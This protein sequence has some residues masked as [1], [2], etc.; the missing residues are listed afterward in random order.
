M[1]DG[2]RALFSKPSHPPAPSPPS[3]SAEMRPVP[4]AGPSSTPAKRPRDPSPS[5]S[6]T[7]R[8][9]TSSDDDSDGGLVAPAL[10]GSQHLAL[11]A[12]SPAPAPQPRRAAAVKREEEPDAAAP[13]AG[14]S[15]AAPKA[16][17]AR[18]GSALKRESTAEESDDEEAEAEEEE[19]QPPSPAPKRRRRSS[20]AAKS[21]K[22]KGKGK[23][24]KEEAAV[25]EEESEEDD[26]EVVSKAM[27]A[28][29]LNDAES[30]S[31]KRLR[32]GSAP[33][34]HIGD[35]VELHPGGWHACVEDIRTL[36]S[37]VRAAVDPGTTPVDESAK[38]ALQLSW[39][40][41][42]E[43]LLA[44]AEKKDNTK[45]FKE[46]ARV[47]GPSERVKTDWV[48][49]HWQSMLFSEKPE[50]MYVFDDSYPACA[51][52]A[53]SPSAHRL[54][55]YSTKALH[56]LAPSAYA[57][58]A[59][60]SP[61]RKQ[62]AG[63]PR[64]PALPDWLFGVGATCPWAGEGEGEKLDEGDGVRQVPYVRV[65]FSFEKQ[66]PHGDSDDDEEEEEVRV[67]KGKGWGNTPGT[68]RV[69]PLTFAAHS[70][71]QKPYNPREVQH[72]SRRAQAWFSVS[73]LLAAGH[74][75]RV[76]PSSSGAGAGV[77]TPTP[78][79]AAGGAKGTPKAGP[80]KTSTTPGSRASAH[81]TLEIPLRT[82]S[83]SSL[84]STT[85]TSTSAA[86]VADPLAALERLSK[87]KIVRGGAYGLTGNAYLSLRAGTLVAQLRDTSTG[88]ARANLLA[89]GRAHL[90]RARAWEAEVA[91]R[92]AGAGEGRGLAREW[93]S[94]GREGLQRREERDGGVWEWVCPRSGEGI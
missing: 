18:W 34:I 32:S 13:S 48:D 64:P 87:A 28:R 41:S 85:S 89:E 65:G 81:F 58:P 57:E 1:L 53:F 11:A 91:R 45:A 47:L 5:P 79:K 31:Y 9:A 22:G 15:S 40:C 42:R 86:A 75:R 26:D 46:P 16:K 74:C 72:F 49:W 78:S 83:R 14:A 20:A 52:S 55:H 10:L 66:V 35:V 76:V 19:E 62:R 33:P 71:A 21:T 80:S 73:D 92:A 67:G 56:P 7:A 3:S 27:I 43:D 30:K 8:I 60:K 4:V 84:A 23:K 12:P 29:L 82:P 69:R 61:S 94:R 36:A 24:E 90:A 17:R 2:L 6:F 51:P 44:Q 70:L 63:D 93:R 25:D 39:F 77:G 38:V 68:A 59:L 37:S 50:T 54:A 88:A